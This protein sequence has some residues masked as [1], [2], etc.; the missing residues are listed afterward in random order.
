L[1]VSQRPNL[2]CNNRHEA[3]AGTISPGGAGRLGRAS[4]IS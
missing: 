2:W 1:A 4:H 3:D